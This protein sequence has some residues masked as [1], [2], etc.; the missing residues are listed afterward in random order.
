MMLALAIGI[1]SYCYFD[2]KKNIGKF[3][4]VLKFIFGDKHF[5]DEEKK[6]I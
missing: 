2:G 4:F 5:E 1:M 6:K 3:D